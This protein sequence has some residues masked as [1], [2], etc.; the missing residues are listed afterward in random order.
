METQNTD[1]TSGKRSCEMSNNDSTGESLMA[2]LI[3]V[4]TFLGLFIGALLLGV[5]FMPGQ[6]KE[7]PVLNESKWERRHSR[8]WQ[9]HEQEASCA[10]PPGASGP[11]LPCDPLFIGNPDI[12]THTY[13]LVS[14]S[15]I[16][17]S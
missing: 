10:Q 12:H 13:L 11:E 4:L 7:R 5:K 8:T 14:T 15:N 17:G 6:Y 9:C 3:F 1:K 16:S 2:M